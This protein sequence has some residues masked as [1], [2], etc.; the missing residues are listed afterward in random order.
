MHV[1]HARVQNQ[2]ANPALLAFLLSPPYLLHASSACPRAT[3][4]PVFGS[5]A[6]E[7][8]SS[9]HCL[10]NH[11]YSRSKLFSCCCLLRHLWPVAP[12]TPPT[13]HKNSDWEQRVLGGIRKSG[14]DPRTQEKNM[15]KRLSQSCKWRKRRQD[16]LKTAHASKVVNPFTRAL[17]PPFI[18]RRRDFYISTIPLN[19]KNIPSVNTYTN[20][21]YI[22]YIYKPATSSYAKPGLFETTSLTLL[23]ANSWISPFRKSPRVVI[24][25]LVLH[26]TP[27]FH[28]FPILWLRTFM[29]SG[30]HEFATS[31]LRR[32]ETSRSSHVRDFKASH[33]H[34]FVSSRVRDF[35]ASQIRDFQIIARSRLQGFAC[36]WLR[37]FT[38]S[39][40]RGFAD[41]R[42]WITANSLFLKTHFTNFMNLDV[43][44]VTSFPEFP[45][46]GLIFTS[47]SWRHKNYFKRLRSLEWVWTKMDLL[48]QTKPD[49]MTIAFDVLWQ[50]PEF[51]EETRD[52]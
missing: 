4:L 31:R 44:R 48:Q 20:V 46:R 26:Q 1:R 17:T 7:F 24:P 16:L 12:A 11:Y 15:H 23:L 50:N 14:Q 13:T 32:F 5:S 33:V 22:S 3:L 51:K 30:L 18:G 6:A 36:S 10:T 41:S 52:V 45:N 29:A 42:L 39:R 43:S 49:R 34:G 21:F 8:A 28:R 2:T 35:E 40:L 38:G 27:E 47:R 37:V 19:S 9:N 25:E